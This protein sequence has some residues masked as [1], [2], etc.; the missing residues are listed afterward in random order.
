MLRIIIK[1]RRPT[2]GEICSLIT[3]IEIV[4]SCMSTGFCFV[5][6]VEQTVSI[7][8]P[9]SGMKASRAISAP[10]SRLLVGLCDMKLRDCVRRVCEYAS[11]SSGWRLRSAHGR[12]R[13]LSGVNVR[14]NGLSVIGRAYFSYSSQPKGRKT[15][16]EKSVL[17]VG[18]FPFGRSTE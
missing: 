12:V 9:Q 15:F 8:E 11:C 17:S 10:S 14:C 13:R 16:G 3:F 4:L 1:K 18:D 2:K 5:I 7:Q 6:A